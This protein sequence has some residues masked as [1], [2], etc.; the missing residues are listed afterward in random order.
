LDEVSIAVEEQS[1]DLLGLDEALSV[2]E[3]RDE[4]KARIVMLR[5]FTGL[6]IEQTAAALGLS[7]TTVK[8]EWAFARAWLHSELTRRDDAEN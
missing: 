7:V 3:Q 6:T 5:Y 2:L 8:D 4:R 1:E